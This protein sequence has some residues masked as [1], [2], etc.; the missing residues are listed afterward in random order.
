MKNLQNYTLN[1]RGS[2]LIELMIVVAVMLLLLWLVSSTMTGSGSKGGGVKG[3]AERTIQQINLN[4][5]YR[6]GFYAYGLDHNDNYPSSK[7]D[8]RIIDDQT[9]EIFKIMVEDGI[10]A[11]MFLSANEYN[12]QFSIGSPNSFGPENTS[13]ALPDYDANNW[14]RYEMWNMNSRSDVMI[15]SD[16]WI[17]DPYLPERVHNLQAGTD[18]GV[19]YWNFLFNDGHSTTSEEYILPN[20]DNVFENDSNLGKKDTLMVHD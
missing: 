3:K 13:F 17:D 20:G 10:P 11:Q 18:E 5:I 15:L 7:T 1:R 19:G 12:D 16:R 8:G 9:H 14:L 4:E 6:A 2:S